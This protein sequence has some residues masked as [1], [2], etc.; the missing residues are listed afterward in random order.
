MQVSGSSLIVGMPVLV[1]AVVTSPLEVPVVPLKVLAMSLHT[2]VTLLPLEVTAILS[3]FIESHV[4]LRNAEGID[5]FFPTPGLQPE[6]LYTEIPHS[7]RVNEARPD[8]LPHLPP[9]GL[10]SAGRP[11]SILV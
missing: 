7:L 6:I 3:R 2:T 4:S 8:G 9:T 11:D 1:A 10:I 5:Y